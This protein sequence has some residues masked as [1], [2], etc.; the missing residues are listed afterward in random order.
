M[1]WLSCSDSLLTRTRALQKKQRSGNIAPPT[2]GRQS[3]M[4]SSRLSVVPD[5]TPITRLRPH[6]PALRPKLPPPLTGSPFGSLPFGRPK[7]HGSLLAPRYSHL[8]EEAIAVS[9]D[10]PEPQPAIESE[11]ADVSVEFAISDNSSDH[12]EESFDSSAGVEHDDPPLTEQPSP[13]LSKRVKGFFFSYLPTLSKS[14]PPQKSEKPRS[15]QLGLPLPPPELLGKARGPISTPARPPLP[16]AVPPKEQVHLQHAPSPKKPALPRPQKPQRLVALHPTPAP[17]P[18]APIPIQRNRRS[19]GGSVKDLVRS[20]EDL[21]SEVT[22][23][24]EIKRVRS[25]GDWKGERCKG[26]K[27]VWRP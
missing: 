25:I 23:K 20:F 9:Q 19:S 22:K 5:F 11:A 17:T 16:R 21:D 13:G 6:P 7:V 3:P 24:S 18:T 8:L 14:T 15:T 2:P 26:D 12:P 1:F 27:P 4:S 10:E